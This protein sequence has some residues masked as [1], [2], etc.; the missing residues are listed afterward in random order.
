METPW[1]VRRGVEDTEEQ[2][3]VSHHIYVLGTPSHATGCRHVRG[4]VAARRIQLEGPDMTEL[5]RRK[6]LCARD[7]AFHSPRHARMGP[8]RNARFDRGGAGTGGRVFVFFSNRLGCMGS[9]V[10]SL[11][12][13]LFLLL[14]L[15]VVNF[16]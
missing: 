1:G 15:G 4:P 6:I 11:V 8:R 3:V 7:S 16:N 9:I 13:T 2:K 12:G 14:L 10:A 5:K